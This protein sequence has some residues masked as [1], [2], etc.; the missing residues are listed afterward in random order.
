M[1]RLFRFLKANF[2]AFGRHWSVYVLLV[3]SINLVLTSLIVPGLTWGV[4]RLLVVNGI[5]YLTYTNFVS[6]LTKHP[7]VLISLVLLVLLICGLVYIQMA[8]LFRQIKRIQEQTPASQWQLLKQSGHDLLTLKPLTMLIMIGYFLLI[9]PFGQIIFKSVLLNKVTIPAFI[10]QDM[11]TT[12]KIW[13]PI[14]LVYT[15]ALILSIRLITFLPETIFNKK[16]STTR[17]LQKCWQMTRG[18]FWRLLIKVGVLATAITLVGVLSQ[19]LLFNLQRYYDQNL[20]H[21]ALLLAI[22]NL[23]ILEIISQI[24]LAMSIVMILQLILKQAGY[25]VPSETRVKVIL[26]HRSLR[27]RMRQGAA[28]LLLILVAA[29]VDLYDYAY[30]EGAMDNRPALISHRGVDDG[31]GVQNTIPAL[32]KTAREKPDYIEMD[33]QET[34]D[35][36]FVVMHDN[37]L[38]E[39]AGVNRTVHELTLAELTT[40]TVRENGYS[41]KIPSF[42]QYLTAAEKAHQR[43]LVEIKVSPQDS[44]QM[45]TNFIKRL[46]ATA[47]EKGQS[48]PFVELSSRS[49]VEETSTALIC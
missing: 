35:H 1:R 36:Q 5:G 17:L 37:N 12:P 10:I 28:M 33:I 30:L 7:L 8:F 46:P 11:W 40:L 44:P 42:D 18:R 39:L 43:L 29:G 22:L 32:Q 19:L 9:L 4:N 24:L 48:Y 27:I 21:Y 2:Q 13:G 45:M 49:G 23:F 6:V 20:L 26:K 31:N 15:L 41:A 34:K 25:L 3:V 47:I 38:E 16:L 14:I